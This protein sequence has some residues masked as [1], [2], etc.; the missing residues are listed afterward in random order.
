MAGYRAPRKTRTQRLAE[1]KNTREARALSDNEIPAF[2]RLAEAQGWPF[3]P[4]LQTL[5]LTGQRRTE[6]AM[7]RWADIDL[8]AAVWNIPAEDTKS[9]RAHP[10]PLPPE[11]VDTLAGLPRRRRCPYVFPGRDGAVLSG[12]S[13]RLRPVYEAWREAKLEPWT[14]HDLRR[15]M[16]SG[17]SALGVDQTVAEMMLNHAVGDELR[18]IY[19]KHGYPEAREEAAR[20]WSSHVFDLVDNV[21]TIRAGDRA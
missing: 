16:R 1:E 21:V 7:M 15:T 11:L 18:R 17:L 19:D 6:T 2:W 12:W 5:L 8:D 9:G 3:G 4:Y 14:L 20:L 13:K 10:V